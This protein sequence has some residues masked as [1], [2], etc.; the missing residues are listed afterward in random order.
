M[1]AFSIMASSTKRSMHLSSGR[2]GGDCCAGIGYATD[3]GAKI[4]VPVAADGTFELPRSEEAAR[5]GGQISSSKMPTSAR[6]G[7]FGDRGNDEY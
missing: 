1:P 5:Q 2:A 6:Q 3:D 7:R 4:A